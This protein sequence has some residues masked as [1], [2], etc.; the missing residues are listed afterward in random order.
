MH[1]YVL[2]ELYSLQL[3]SLY[4][5]KCINMCRNPVYIAVQGREIVYSL[6]AAQNGFEFF[7]TVN[8]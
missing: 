6:E 7:Y 1:T 5:G 2:G 4:G 8:F 3:F